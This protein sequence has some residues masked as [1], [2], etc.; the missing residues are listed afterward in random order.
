LNNGNVG[1]G[2]TNGFWSTANFIDP[3]GMAAANIMMPDNL[4]AGYE[5]RLNVSQTPAH[6]AIG[7][8][9]GGTQGPCVACHMSSPRKHVFSPVSSASSGAITAIT[10]PLCST[11]HGVTAFTIDAGYIETKKEGYQA[12][13]T[14][15]AA[16]LAARGV[17]FNAA[18]PPY[19]FT[20]NVVASQGPATRVTN[21]NAPAPLSQGAQLMG[22]ALNLRLHQSDAG[23]VHNATSS[24]RLLYDTI[25]YLD[26]GNPANNSVAVTIQNLA[27]VDQTTKVRATAYLI[28]RP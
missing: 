3:H 19:F 12:A 9:E 5:Y 10:S 25:D 27:G 28:P 15:I 26:D 6:A 1:L 23:W 20:T 13:L 2:L 7:F 11:C 16:Q 17:Y 4:R 18:K 8:V 14:V 22:A 24:K 21:W